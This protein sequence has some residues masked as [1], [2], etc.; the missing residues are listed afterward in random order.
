MYSQVM[1]IMG[2]ICIWIKGY[3][4][5]KKMVLVLYKREREKKVHCIYT[6]QQIHIW[7]PVLTV[8]RKYRS[9]FGIN[10][11]VCSLV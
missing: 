1:I 10:A 11:G 6:F 5:W 9:P 7:I 4:F 8:L 3:T 2:V